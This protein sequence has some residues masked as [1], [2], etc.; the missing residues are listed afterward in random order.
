MPRLLPF[1][2]ALL[3]APAAL[4][5]NDTTPAPATGSGLPGPEESI[6]DEA[7][8]S[9]GIAILVGTLAIGGLL[10]WVTRRQRPRHP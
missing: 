1:L 10:A 6:E 2:L 7:G 4:A 3:L 8:F 5:Q 9:Y